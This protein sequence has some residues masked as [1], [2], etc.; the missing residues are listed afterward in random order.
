M[1]DTGLAS[2]PVAR[3]YVDSMNSAAA[4][5]LLENWTTDGCAT[6]CL[7][8]NGCQ[9]A[10]PG[11]TGGCTVNNSA[12]VAFQSWNGM[13]NGRLATNLHSQVQNGMP[14][15]GSSLLPAVAF[16]LGRDPKG[17]LS[18]RSRPRV[19][20]QNRFMN[21][22]L[23]T[24]VTLFGFGVDTVDADVQMFATQ[25]EMRSGSRLDM[26]DG[27]QT[28]DSG[29][30][31]S[32]WGVLSTDTSISNPTF[33]F[34][35]TF[36]PAR[37]SLLWSALETS[38]PPFWSD[39]RTN[40]VDANHV[41]PF[42]SNDTGM[43]LAWASEF[44][45]GYHYMPV[46]T[47]VKTPNLQSRPAAVEFVDG[48]DDDGDEEVDE[49]QVWDGL[50]ITATWTDASNRWLTF[51]SQNRYWK[52]DSYEDMFVP[53]TGY[54]GQGKFVPDVPAGNA[55]IWFNA[56][57]VDGIK[58]WDGSYGIT[59]AYTAPS[60]GDWNGPAQFIVLF[61]QNR[62]WVY[63]GG[64]DGVQSWMAAGHV[65]DGIWLPRILP[66]FEPSYT[67]TYYGIYPWDYYGITGIHYNEW[68]TTDQI[69]ITSEGRQ[70]TY[71]F[72]DATWSQPWERS[73][74]IT[75][76]WTSYDRSVQCVSAN[77]GCT[78]LDCKSAQYWQGDYTHVSCFG[79]NGG[80]NP[81]NTFDIHAWGSQIAVV[82][83]GITNIIDFTPAAGASCPNV[84]ASTILAACKDKQIC[85]Y[86][87]PQ[88]CSGTA[89]YSCASYSTS[90]WG[91][92]T[93][94]SGGTLGMPCPW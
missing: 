73:G 65:G 36:I 79:M 26:L 94:T 30:P 70:W 64:A 46:A 9:S 60:T 15:R 55:S 11:Y 67:P 77:N 71:N 32:A 14:K 31:G 82:R 83:N 57:L 18:D 16:S 34:Y 38:S 10:Q 44:S 4:R 45:K 78:W 28:V 42:P 7:D 50:G 21:I 85:N 90:D 35:P 48:R 37:S 86:P 49:M 51:V 52:Y 63:R 12:R 68:G 5:E 88:G 75:S 1:K 59:A 54:F 47:A 74:I 6:G 62:Y 80:W 92:A 76:A 22:H 2:K 56:P 39:F 41:S 61:N 91:Q 43:V 53:Q 66:Y 33:D 84:T 3:T 89:R 27:I 13:P 58:P 72:D 29:I 81:I 87:L 17:L 23:H 93:A 8:E 25:E 19:N 69:N 24:N 20:D 40:S